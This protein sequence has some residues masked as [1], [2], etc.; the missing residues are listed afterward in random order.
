M[1]EVVAGTQRRLTNAVTRAAAGARRA[2][3]PGG[4]SSFSGMLLTY[5]NLVPSSAVSSSIGQHVRLRIRRHGS[6]T[7]FKIRPGI[8]IRQLG[9]GRKAIRVRALFELEHNWT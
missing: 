3:G 8:R 9:H 4:P 2:A 1:L 5:C 7:S 6:P